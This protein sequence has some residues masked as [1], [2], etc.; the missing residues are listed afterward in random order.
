MKTECVSPRCSMNG[1][2][3]MSMS[4]RIDIVRSNGILISV[5]NNLAEVLPKMYPKAKCPTAYEDF[6]P[7][8]F[9]EKETATLIR[10][11]QELFVK[12]WQYVKMIPLFPLSLSCRRVQILGFLSTCK[13]VS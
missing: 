2:K 12:L 13:S 11:V 1:L 4:G 7:P 8:F 6:P 9:S 3:R 5:F 10:F